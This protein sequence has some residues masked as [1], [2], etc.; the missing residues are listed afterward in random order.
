MADV[1]LA[2]VLLCAA[3]LL[4]RS[5]VNTLGVDPGFRREGVVTAQAVVPTPLG[6]NL[7]R[8]TSARAATW[9]ARSRHSAPCRVRSRWEQ[10]NVLPL[11][12][13]RTDR[14]L[15]VEGEREDQ[16]AE[17]PIVQHRVVTPGFFETLRLPLLQGRR[18]EEADRAGAPA[19]VVVN[20]SFVRGYFPGGDAL[21]RRLRL[22]SPRP[23]GHHRR[24]GRRRS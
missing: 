15:T 19:V 24:G 16:A 1:G 23:M 14:L 7:D 11:S 8:H 22:V 3:S 12:G 2:L 18:I 5:F 17:K 21:G 13:D 9:S 20:E 10:S 6:T 4:L